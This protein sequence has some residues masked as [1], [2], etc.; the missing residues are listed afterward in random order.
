MT[1]DPEDALAQEAVEGRAQYERRL[2]ETARE[3]HEG[4]VQRLRS[5]EWMAGATSTTVT[6][7]AEEWERLAGILKEHPEPAV[8]LRNLMQRS[9]PWDETDPIPPDAQH[10]GG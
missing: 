3:R 10:L 4:I 6:V 2:L 7:S 8:A 9:A 5:P 1:Q